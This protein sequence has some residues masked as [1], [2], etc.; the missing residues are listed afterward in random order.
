MSFDLPNPI[1]QRIERLEKQLRL[2][3]QIAAGVSLLLVCV[4][5]MGQTPSQRIVEANQFILRDNNGKVRA[6]LSMNDQGSPEMTLLDEEGK[7]RLKLESSVTPFGGGSV[8]VFDRQG[9]LRVFITS[10]L[11]GE[12]DRSDLPRIAGLPEGSGGSISLLNS[13]DR[14]GTTLAAGDI[15]VNGG[16]RLEDDQGYAAWLGRTGLLSGSETRTRN[17]ASIALVDNIKRKVVWHAP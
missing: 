13:Q 11:L 15:W 9:K 12:S 4:I 1:E 16:I 3:K 5:V 10:P 14:P 6:R 8:R 7:P 2:F 17:A